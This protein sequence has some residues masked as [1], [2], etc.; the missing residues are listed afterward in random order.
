MFPLDSSE[1]AMDRIWVS[2]PSPKFCKVKREIAREQNM[3]IILMTQSVSPIVCKL[4]DYKG[5]LYGQFEQKIQ[6][7]L[8]KKS[9]EAF[10]PNLIQISD[11]IS[12]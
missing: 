1:K 2:I 11:R 7:N 6:G 5:K 4:D 10:E 12:M 9:Q 3:D 8:V